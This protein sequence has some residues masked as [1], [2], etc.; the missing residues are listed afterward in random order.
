M[1]HLKKLVATVL[2]FLSVTVNLMA[3][4]AATQ[5]IEMADRL[6]EDG[7]IWVVVGVIALIFAGIVIYLVRLDSKI[8]KL[9]KK[10]S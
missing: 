2:L 10:I 4:Q 1:I 9:E 5:D 6:R 7:K 8:S 3:Q